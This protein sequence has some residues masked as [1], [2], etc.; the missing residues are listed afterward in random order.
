MRCP[1]CNGADLREGAGEYLRNEDGKATDNTYWQNCLCR[2]C[3]F[4]WR[5]WF[6]LVDL[7]EIASD[8]APAEEAPPIVAFFRFE[9]L[10]SRTMPREIAE[11][12]GSE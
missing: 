6:Q 3:G 12:I 10:D 1:M 5:E 8:R 11:I 9:Q 7:E 2:T 4:A